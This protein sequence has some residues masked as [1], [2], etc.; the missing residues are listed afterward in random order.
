MKSKVRLKKLEQL[1]LME[2]D[3]PP[4]LCFVPFDFPKDIEKEKDCLSYQKQI[5]AQKIKGA[6][7]GAIFLFCEGCK[8]VC[9]YARPREK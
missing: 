2:E 8:E 4:L 6:F 7:G 3:E 9:S 1:L 5:E